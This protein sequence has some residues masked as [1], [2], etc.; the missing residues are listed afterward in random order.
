MFLA[1]GWVWGKAGQSETT[2]CVKPHG[3]PGDLGKGVEICMKAIF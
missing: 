2:L 3:L 1:A